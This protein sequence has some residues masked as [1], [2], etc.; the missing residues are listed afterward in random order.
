MP[1]APS[2][3]TVNWVGDVA[4]V[5]VHG[6][7]DP[8][9]ASQVRERIGGVAA[10][11]PARMVLDLTGV[12]ERYGAECLALIAVTQHLLPQGSALDVRSDSRAVRQILALAD[13]AIAQESAGGEK[14]KAV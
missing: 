5:T 10:S 7:L 8:D 14:P 13:Q 2:A 1:K 6:G 12:A 4:T 3:V 11:R 9:S